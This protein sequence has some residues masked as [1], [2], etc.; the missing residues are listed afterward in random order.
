ME[1]GSA[2]TVIMATRLCKSTIHKTLYPSLKLNHDL[3]VCYSASCL[4]DA[5]HYRCDRRC[6]ALQWR[7]ENNQLEN[8]WVDLC[9]LVHYS[10]CVCSYLWLSHGL[11]P[12]RSSVAQY[13]SVC[14]G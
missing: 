4:D 7:L 2:F 10:A 11:H 12:Q 13:V 6:W 5:M 3:I 8:G 1:L 9:G 14:D